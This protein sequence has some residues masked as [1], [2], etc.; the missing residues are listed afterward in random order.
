MAIV[1]EKKVKVRFQVGLSSKLPVI[2]S[3]AYLNRRY[4]T[5]KFN[6]KMRFIKIKNTHLRNF[7]ELGLEYEEI[8]CV[9]DVTEII[10]YIKKTGL[11]EVG[12]KTLFELPKPL[13]IKP[14]LEGPKNM[15][16]SMS[17]DEYDDFR[18]K[19]YLYYS[20][21][22]PHPTQNNILQDEDA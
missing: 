13:A 18:K 11:S 14:M 9:Y 20:I 2:S 21:R 4:H 6:K 15:V 10:K 12:I 16:N 7:E 5:L 8:E 19:L 3:Y 1:P 22:I 17:F